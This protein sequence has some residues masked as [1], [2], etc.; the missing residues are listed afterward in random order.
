MALTKV[1]GGILDPG[2]NVAGI[3]TATGFDG[4]FTG[5]SSK[6]INAGTVTAT[7]LDINGNGDIS[8]N[9]VVGGNLTANGDFTTLNTTLR[10]VEILHVSAGSTATAGIITQTSTGDILQLYDGSTEVFSVAD[11]GLVEVKARAA[12]TKRVVLAGSP[13]NTT[14]QLA[15]YD[16][17]TGTGAGTTQA[18]FGLFYNYQE[19]A[20][21]KF[22]RG[23]GSADGALTINTNNTEQLRFL[24]NNDIRATWYDRFVGVYLNSDY[25]VGANFKVQNDQRTLYIDNRT[26]NGRGDIVFRT[27]VNQDPVERLTIR[28]GGN[29][30]IGSTLPGE[31][32][33]VSGITSTTHLNVT[34]VSTFVG[35][36]TFQDDVNVVQGKKINFGDTDG[37]KGHIYYDGSTTRFQTNQGLNIGAPVVSLKGAGL[38]GVMGEFIAGGAVQLYHNNLLRLETDANGVQIKPNSG[39]VTQLGIAQTTTTAHSINGSISFINSSNTTAQIQGRTGSASTTGDMIFLC[40]TVGDETLAVLEDGKVRVPDRG[41]FVVGQGND[42]TLK[43]NVDH[44]TIT[45]TTGDLDIQSNVIRLKR[46]DAGQTF[47][48]FINNGQAE[49]SFSGNTKLSTSLTGITVTGEVAASQ[50]YPD[51]R[52]TLDFNFVAEKKLDTKITYERT[53]PASFTNEFGKVVLVGGNV[54]RFDHDPVTRECKGLLIEE[55]RTNYCRSSSDLSNLWSAGGGSYAI[56]SAITNPDGTVGAHYHTGAE[57]YHTMDLSGASTNTIRISM[58]VKERSGQSGNMDIQI[59]EQVSGSVLNIG[60][61]GFNP[62]TGVLTASSHSSNERVVEYPNGWYRIAF[63]MTA[64]TAN[65]TASSRLDLQAAEHYV[66]GIQVEIGAFETS[67]IPTSGSTVT[68]GADTTFIDG[69]DFTDFYNQPEGTIVSSHSLLDDIPATHNVYTYQVAPDSGTSEAPFRLIDRNGAYGNTLVATSITNNAIVAF[70]KASGDPVTPA[71]KKMK[72][73]FAIKTNDFAASFNGG[74]VVTDTSGTVSQTNDHLAIGY[75]KPSPQAYLNGH[76]QRLMYYPSRLSNTQL[77]NLSS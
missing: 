27:G 41:S 20:V 66:W 31:A 19:P 5:G 11:G 23:S 47:A 10:E 18:K 3:V 70:F 24:S 52:P 26:V 72:V 39:G 28:G 44:S 64:Q 51:L 37:T 59:Y 42:L 76:I 13:T 43:H 50:D 15:A 33:V 56:D 21:L 75:Y 7:E 40:N 35:V 62:A 8:G 1:S 65:F 77:Q 67:F 14:F 34:G 53:G 63:T 69:D 45:N 12:D 36:S 9:L 25:Y 6:N 71:N 74:T 38:V 60:G 48:S 57:L 73:A 58:W 4:P 54:P 16:G 17:E 55:S 46:T 30:G 49:F 68:R 29:V 22:E 2:I 61:P 32:L